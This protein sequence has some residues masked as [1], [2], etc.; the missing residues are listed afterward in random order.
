M[1]ALSLTTKTE[2]SIV[3]IGHEQIITVN[4]SDSMITR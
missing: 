2:V 3:T 1:V 4:A